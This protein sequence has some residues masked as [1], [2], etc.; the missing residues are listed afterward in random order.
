MSLFSSNEAGFFPNFLRAYDTLS[1]PVNLTLKAYA[2]DGFVFDGICT[3]PRGKLPKQRGGAETFNG[4]RV[5]MD[6]LN[7]ERDICQYFDYLDHNNV[8]EF[9]LKNGMEIESM[10]CQEMLKNHRLREVADQVQ[11]LIGLTSAYKDP[12]PTAFVAKIPPSGKPDIRLAGQNGS[13][14]NAYDSD[15]KVNYVPPTDVKTCP[16]SAY[17]SFYHLFTTVAD[18]VDGLLRVGGQ[19]D[20]PNFDYL[21]NACRHVELFTGGTFLCVEVVRDILE[22][23]SRLNYVK[24]SPKF[25]LAPP[26]TLRDS[27]KMVEDVK[28]EMLEQ[29]G[30]FRADLAISLSGGGFLIPMFIGFMDYMMEI[31]MFNMSTPIAGSSAGA[32]TLVTT[33]MNTV[34]RYDKMVLTETLCEHI[35][36]GTP[37]GNLDEVAPGRLMRILPPGTYKAMNERVGTAQINYAA[38]HNGEPQSRFVTKASSDKDMMDALR[39]SCN[40]PGF[41]TIGPIKY[42]GEDAYDGLF[43]TDMYYMGALK[44]PARR[45]VRFVPFPIGYGRTVRKNLLNDVANAYLQK[46]EEYYVHYI[47]LKSLTKQ[48]TLRRLEYEHLG[49]LDEWRKELTL[50]LSVYKTICKCRSDV[51]YAKETIYQW[52]NIMSAKPGET[53]PM[54]SKEKDCTLPELFKLVVASERSLHLGENT[55]M[56][57]GAV[58]EPLAGVNIMKKYGYPLYPAAEN[59]AHFLGTPHTVKEWLSYELLRLDKKAG[60]KAATASEEEIDLLTEMLHHLS[61]PDSFAYYFT[62]FPYMIFSSLIEVQR[63]YASFYPSQVHSLRHMFDSGRTIGLRW[64]LNEYINFENWLYLRIKQLREAPNMRRVVQSRSTP[65]E[66][67]THTPEPIHLQQHKK[68]EANVSMLKKDKIMELFEGF[69]KRSTRTGL[70]RRLFELQNRLV[71]R[72]LLYGVVDTHFAH[73]LGHRHFW[74]F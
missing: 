50:S 36:S 37:R 7:I 1:Q 19:I 34:N 53:K 73:I 51:R 60:S 65:R 57:A 22:D 29:R 21:V 10:N 26:K 5:Y 15:F 16:T 67:S 55:Y 12:D 44:A 68:L 41:Y 61:P 25:T 72:A 42:K 20:G 45:T 71:R 32:I 49:M 18:A 33:L 11:E 3:A 70:R 64:L 47:R 4:P 2:E 17:P 30:I 9:F 38:V 56:H 31:N 46:K 28:K 63:V 43:A 13:S 54:A 48:L 74:I 58:D 35:R 14:Y 6:K 69:Q 62:E 23:Y 59:D 24:L 40:V 8:R 66:D 52:A 39:A 27:L